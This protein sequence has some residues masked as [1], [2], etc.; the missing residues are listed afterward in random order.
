VLERAFGNP[1]RERRNADTARVQRAHEIVESFALGTKQ[2]LGGNLDV[3]EHQRPCVRRP[4]PQ[5]VLFS[6][7]AEAGHRWERS[8]MSDA[9]AISLLEIACLLRDDKSADALGSNA[10]LSDGCHD[11]Y[12]PYAPVSNEDFRAVE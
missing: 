12:L 9:K 2:V 3:L 4:P 7:G 6:S 8:I 10:R 11:E 5:L 1:K